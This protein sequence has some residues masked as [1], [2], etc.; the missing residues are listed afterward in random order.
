MTI[1]A[2]DNL[3]FEGQ[4]VS[5]GTLPL[6]DYFTKANISPDFHVFNTGC[7]RGYIGTWA[8]KDERLYLIHISATLKTGEMVNL[9]TIFPGYPERV[10]AHWFSGII[11]IP[12]GRNLDIN[13]LIGG[14]GM[15]IYERDMLLILEK[16]V[17]IKRQLRQ[18]AVQA[19]DFS[20]DS[21]SEY[22]LPEN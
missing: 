3:L 12:M 1:Q 15:G 11:Q 22:T 21:R 6:N 20:N 16:G 5:I 18:N 8:I 13:F 19:S 2:K 17:V 14:L 10:F 9:E 7:W 4:V